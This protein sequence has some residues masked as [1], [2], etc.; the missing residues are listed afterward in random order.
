MH[1]RRIYIHLHT[2]TH[3]HKT[4]IHT[5]IHIKTNSYAQA[6]IQTRMNIY[7][8]RKL[9]RNHECIHQRNVKSVHNHFSCISFKNTTQFIITVLVKRFC[10]Q[11]K[12]NNTRQV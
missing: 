6:H 3:T 10:R 12:A 8:N 7:I 2:R 1:I 4:H 9:A 5:N 11:L